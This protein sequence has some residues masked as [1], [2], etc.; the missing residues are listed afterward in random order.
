MA[1]N[2]F[3][4]LNVNRGLAG[5]GSVFAPKPRPHPPAE[6]KPGMFDKQPAKKPDNDETVNAG[7]IERW[8]TLPGGQKIPIKTKSG[9]GMLVRKPGSDN[10][11][12]P[13]D[14]TPYQID[15]L[16]PTGLKDAFDVAPAK[17]DGAGRLVKKV[18]DQVRDVGEDAEWVKKQQEA[19]TKKTAGEAKKAAAAE[20]KAA[21]TELTQRKTEELVRIGQA[22]TTLEERDKEARLVTRTARR[23]VAIVEDEIKGDKSRLDAIEN[24]LEAASGDLDKTAT[25]EAEKVK[26]AELLPAKEERR[27]KLKLNAQKA[28]LREEAWLRRSNREQSALEREAL[29]VKTMTNTGRRPSVESDT[30]VNAPTATTPP[31]PPPQPIN[32][33]TAYD[34]AYATEALRRDA[35]QWNAALTDHYGRVEFADSLGRSAAGPAISQ[36]VNRVLNTSIIPGM[37]QATA[38]DVMQ[39]HLPKVEGQR[40]NNGT[41]LV[42]NDTEVGKVIYQ[43]GVP[44]LRL[45]QGVA[46]IRHSPSLL[47]GNPYDGVPEYSAPTKQ[48]VDTFQRTRPSATL[49]Q[50][51]AGE[52]ADGGRTIEDEWKA[53]RWSAGQVNGLIEEWSAA[54]DGER[55]AIVARLQPEATLMDP[56]NPRLN[57]RRLFQEGKVSLQEARLLERE[58]YGIQPGFKPLAQAW[59]EYKASDAAKEMRDVL[60]DSFASRRQMVGALQQGSN[61]FLADYYKANGQRADFDLQEFNRTRATLMDEEAG[62]AHWTAAIDEAVQNA[63][64]SSVGIAFGLGK[65]FTLQTSQDEFGMIL[66]Q[67]GY[68]WAGLTNNLNDRGLKLMDPMGSAFKAG[69]NLLTGGKQ[70]WK[71]LWHGKEGSKVKASVETLFERID[72]ESLTETEFED[73][74]REILRSAVAVGRRAEF[75]EATPE[76]ER[77][78]LEDVREYYDPADPRSPLAG[79]L[80]A[81]QATRDPAI[82]AQFTSLL[83]S[84]PEEQDLQQKVSDYASSNGTVSADEFTGPL[85]LGFKG[86]QVAPVQE[87]LIEAVSNLASVGMGKLLTGGAKQAKRLQ[88]AGQAMNAMQKT[89][90]RIE[91]A[92]EWFAKAGTR[93][94]AT[95]RNFLIQGG[96]QAVTS[97]LGEGF[98][99]SV[100]AFTE[101]GASIGDAMAQGLTGIIGGIGLAPVHGLAGLALTTLDERRRD[102]LDSQQVKT[103]EDNWNKTHPEDP[104][105]EQDYRQMRAYLDPKADQSPA[106]AQAMT[107]LANN[108]VATRQLLAA[109]P[110]SADVLTPL[111]EERDQLMQQAQGIAAAQR[112][113]VVQAKQAMQEING[114]AEPSMRAFA[115]AAL[116]ARQGVPLTPKEQ[117]TLLNSTNDAGEV[118][119]EQGATGW[120]LTEAGLNSLGAAVPWTRQT[121]FPAEV[122]PA[123]VAT[124]TAPAA[125]PAGQTP[126]KQQ[127]PASGQP[128]TPATP[129]QTNPAGTT[130]APAAPL[131]T[132]KSE[133]AGAAVTPSSASSGPAAVAG[134]PTGGGVEAPSGEAG[135]LSNYPVAIMLNFPDGKVRRM[136]LEQQGTSPEDAAA[137]AMAS[138]AMQAYQRR[139][140]QVETL[141][142]N[143]SPSASATPEAGLGAGAA[144]TPTPEG[145]TENQAAPPSETLPE[146]EMGQRDPAEGIKQVIER[147]DAAQQRESRLYG[148]LLKMFLTVFGYKIVDTGIPSGYVD[149]WGT[150]HNLGTQ[151]FD[152]MNPGSDIGQWIDKVGN[153]SPDIVQHIQENMTQPY[154]HRVWFGHDPVANLG[155]IVEQFGVSALPEYALQ[156]LKDS[157]TK[158]GIP[159][160]GTQ[161]LVQSGLVGDR[162][163]TNWLS[164]NIGEALSGGLAIIGTYKLARKAKNGDPYSSGWAI[165]GVGFKLVGGAIQSNPVLILSG[166]TDLGILVA[167][168]PADVK[169]AVDLIAKQQAEPPETATTVEE[170]APE[171]P[172][173]ADTT[174]PPAPTEDLPAYGYL[175]GDAVAAALQGIP[176]TKRRGAIAV[177]DAL[178]DALGDY[179]DL[180]AA[181]EFQAGDARMYLR[182]DDALVIDLPDLVREYA[183]KPANSMV[184]LVRHELIHYAAGQVMSAQEMSNLWQ[185]LPYAIQNLVYKAYFAADILDEAR[186]SNAPSRWSSAEAY[187]M[188]HEFIRALVEESEFQGFVTEAVQADPNVGERIMRFLRTFVVRIREMLG[189]LPPGHRADVAEYE[190]RVRNALREMLGRPPLPS[191]NTLRSTGQRIE[192]L[193]DWSAQ[194]PADAR[195]WAA[196]TDRGNILAI[197]G[198]IASTSWDARKRLLTLARQQGEGLAYDAGMVSRNVEYTDATQQADL[199]A[200]QLARRGFLNDLHFAPA[201]SIDIM[202]QLAEGADERDYGWNNPNPTPAQLER[203]RQL[204]E[205]QAGERF[206]TDRESLTLESIP[207]LMPI[208]T[209][210]DLET[211]ETDNDTDALAAMTERLA[212]PEQLE[213]RLDPI[214]RRRSLSGK[215]D[216]TAARLQEQEAKLKA[217]EAQIEAFE[218]T[219]LAPLMHEEVVAIKQIRRLEKLLGQLER[220]LLAGIPV[221]ARQLPAAAMV[222]EVEQEA[223]QPPAPDAPPPATP[224]S[225]EAKQKAREAFAGLIDDTPRPPPA[226]EETPP[227]P[228][229]LA[230]TPD[231]EKKRRR[232]AEP[233]PPPPAAEGVGS[234]EAK[235]KARAAFAGLI[236]DTTTAPPA[237]PASPTPPEA[238]I[239]DFGQKIG[240]ARKDTWKAT[241]LNVD[242]LEG[243]TP[244]ERASFV[245]KD[246]VWPKP[247]YAVWVDAGMP[248]AVAM[249]IKRFRDALPTMPSSITG[250]SFRVPQGDMQ[251]QY[252]EVLSI[253]RDKMPFAKTRED[254]MAIWNEVTQYKGTGRTFN[255]H[256]MALQ[257]ATG[258]SKSHYRWTKLFEKAV[259]DFFNSWR[260]DNLE[261]EVAESG[262]PAAGEPWMKA[263]RI[264]TVPVGTRMWTREKGQIVTT[265]PHF[266]V[267]SARKGRS[268]VILSS[269]HKTQESAIAWAKTRYELDQEGRKKAGGTLSRPLKPDPKRESSVDYRRNMNMTGEDLVEAFK[270]RGGEFGNWTNQ[271]DRQQALNFAYD[272]MQ[273]L[274]RILGI[275]PKAVSLNG[276][277]GIA[278]GARGKGKAAAHYELSKVVINLTRTSGAGALA[279]EW[280]H[281]LDHYFGSVIAQVGPLAMLSDE[282]SIKLRNIRPEMAEA[283]V[284]V[285]RAIMLKAKDLESVITE[286]RA[287]V[288]R[289]KKSFMSWIPG[290]RDTWSRDLKDL[291]DAA[292]G[293]A[294]RM[295]NGAPA[296]IRDFIPLIL[297]QVTADTGKAFRKS[298][299]FEQN[300]RFLEYKENILAKAEA[301]EL[302]RTGE[303]PTRYAENAKKLGAYWERR[304]ELFARAF[305]SYIQDRLEGIGEK[306]EYLVHSA[307]GGATGD[308][309]WGTAY[310]EGDE[311]AAIFKA[312]D[313]LFGTVQQEVTETGVRL[314]APRPAAA[315]TAQLGLP[316]ARLPA[317]LDLAQTLI[318]EQINTPAALAAFLDGLFPGGAA[319]P[320]SQAL[321]DALGMVDPTLRGT[322]DWETVYA[323]EQ[324]APEATPEASN[325]T[326]SSEPTPEQP[327]PPPAAEE[328]PEDAPETAIDD[329]TAYRKAVEGVEN[330]IRFAM[331]KARVQFTQPMLLDTVAKAMGTP[332]SAGVWSIKDATDI[333]EV[334]INRILARPGELDI[335]PGQGNVVM[336]QAMVMRLKERLMA[337]IPTQTRR[338]AEMDRM[339]QF[340]TPPTLSFA[341]AWVGK[342]ED[343]DVLLEPSAGLAGLAMWGKL[344]GAH[345]IANELSPRRVELL[346]L[347]GIPNV[348]TSENAEHLFAIMEPQMKDGTIRRPTLVIMNPPFSNAANVSGTDTMVGARHLEQA[349]KLLAPG[350]RLVAIVGRGMAADK[351][352]FKAWWAKIGK[353]YDVRA[354]IGV[355]G[356]EYA[357]YGTTFDNQ[358]VVIDKLPPNPDR[359]V[360]TGE[361]RTVEELLPLL[362]PVRN[363]RPA[364][365]PGK[366]ESASPEPARPQTDPRP[367]TGGVADPSPSPDTG[368]NRPSGSGARPPRG[369]G[370]SG[371]S[372]T[373]QLD[374]N[375]PASESS[376]APAND[377]TGDTGTPAT[378]P[379]PTR[380]TQ[381][382]SAAS[383]QSGAVRDTAT[384][385]DATPRELSE[386]EVFAE[387]R[388]Q[389]ARFQGSAAHPSP[390]VESAAMGAV[391]APDINYTPNLPENVIQKGLLSDA[392]LEAVTYA[393]QAH[394][395]APLDTG[396]TR[397][398]FIGDGTGVGKGRELSGIIVDNWRQGRRRAVWLSKSKGLARDA[399]RDLDGL[400]FQEIPIV[401][402][403]SAKA[404]A[405]LGFKEGVLFT[406]YSTLRGGHEG[407]DPEGNPRAGTKPSRFKQLVDALGRDFDGVIALDESHMAGNAVD[408]KG[409][410]GVKKASKQGLAIVD[411]Q[412]VFP[413]ARVVYASATGATEPQNFSYAERLGLWGQGTPFPNKVKF[414]DAI[415]AQ[416]VSAMEILARDLKALGSYISRTLSFKGVDYSRTV[417]NVTEDQTKLYDAMARS[418]QMVF[419][420]VDA[421]LGLTNGNRNG[422]ARSAA[423]S[424]F[425]SSNQRFFNQVLTSLQMPTILADMQKRLDEGNSV[426]LQ[427]VN[428]NEAIQERALAEV[429]KDKDEADPLAL[430]MLDMSPKDVL[431]QYVKNGWPTHLYEEIEDDNGNSKYVLVTDAQGKPVESPE[432]I[433]MREETLN[434]LASLQVPDNPL[435]QILDT[436]GADAV[437]EIT[438]RS[439]RVVRKLQP[440]GTM[441]RIVEANRSDARRNVEA[442]EFQ[443]GKRRILIFSDAGGTG[444]SYHAAVGAKN[445]Q[446]RFHYLVQ[447]GWR[448]DNAIQGFG[449]THRSDQ[450]TPPF[451]V[452][453]STNIRGH[454]RFISTIARRLAQLGAL[455]TGER[456]AAGQGMFT[457]TDNLEGE[458]AQRAVRRLFSDLYENKVPGLDFYGLTGRMGYTRTI[459][460][461]RGDEVVVSTLIDPKTGALSVDKTPTVQQFLNRI[462]ALEIAEQNQVFD[463]FLAGM[464]RLIEQA[465]ADGSY[466]PGVQTFKADRVELA[467][468]ETVYTHPGTSSPTRLVTVKAS[469]RI[470]YKEFDRINRNNPTWVRNKRSGRVYAI[471]SNTLTRTTAAGSIVA[472]VWKTSPADIKREDITDFQG[473]RLREYYDVLTPED[474]RPLWEEEIRTGGEF[475]VKDETF[476]V[477]LMLPVWDRAKMP[478]MRV[479]RV[480]PSTPDVEPFLGLHIPRDQVNEVRKRLGAGIAKKTPAAYFED[481]LE[482]GHTLDLANGW[483]VSRVKSFGEPRIEL[484]GPQY[485]HLKEIE[486]WGGFGERISWSFRYFLPGTDKEGIAAFEKLITRHPVVSAGPGLSLGAP[487]PVSIDTAADPSLELYRKRS[488][489]GQIESE[490]WD[491][492]PQWNRKINQNPDTAE[493]EWVNPETPS[494]DIQRLISEY[495]SLA[496]EVGPLPRKG[497]FDPT[498]LLQASIDIAA[499]SAATSPTN[500]LP[501]PTAAQKEAGNYPKGHARISGLDITIENPAG[502][503]RS[504]V[505]KGGKAWS[506]AMKDHYGY[507]KGT[508]GPDGDHL[509]VFIAP[510]TPTDYRGP[511]HVVE[512]G[513]KAGKGFDEHKAII[514]VQTAAEA[515]ELYQRNYAPDW[516]GGKAIQTMPWEVFKTWATSK[517]AA[518][519]LDGRRRLFAPRPVSVSPAGFY[520]TLQEAIRAKLPARATKEQA[521][522][523]VTGN[524]KAE[525]V[526]WSGVLPWIDQQEG[527]VDKEALLAFL[528][529]EGAVEL[530]EVTMGEYFSEVEAW[531]NDEGGAN[532]ETPFW[533]LTP[534][535]QRNAIQQYRDEVAP[536]NEESPKYAQYQLPGA[537]NYREVVLSMTPNTAGAAGMTLDAMARALGFSGWHST[538]TPAQKDQVEKAWAAQP[539]G[540]SN[541][542]GRPVVQPTKQNYTSSHFPNVPNYVAHMRLNERT[543]ATGATGLFVEEL[544]SDRHQA[545]REK[546]Y[547]NQT[548]RSE[549]E[550]ARN[551]YRDAVAH[552]GT[553]PAETASVLYERAHD[554]NPEI[555]WNW[556]KNTE[557]QKWQNKWS[558]QWTSPE[559]Q[560]QTI[561]AIRTQRALIEDLRLKAEQ[562]ETRTRQAIPDAPFRKDWPLALFKRALR[563]AVATGKDWIGWTTGETQAERFDLSKQVEAIHAERRKTF[564]ALAITDKA[565][566]TTEQRVP[567]EKLPDFVGKD[568]ARKIAEEADDNPDGKEYSGLDLK[569]GGE[570]MKGFYDTIL[571]KEIAKYVKQWGATVEKGNAFTGASTKATPEAKAAIERNDRLGFDRTSEALSAVLSDPN[572]AETWDVSPADAAILQDWKNASAQQPIWRISITPAMREGVQRGQPLFAPAPVGTRPKKQKKAPPAPVVSTSSIAE[573]ADRQQAQSAAASR[574][575]PLTR[576]L[577]QPA[578]F[579]QDFN[580]FY[581]NK[582][583]GNIDRIDYYAPG[584]R[585]I[586][587]DTERNLALSR[588][589]VNGLF[590]NLNA[591][592]RAGFGY[593]AWWKNP[594]V[595]AEW[596]RFQA[597]LLPVAARLEADSVDDQGQFVWAPFNM[598]AGQISAKLVKDQK[599][600]EGDTINAGGEMLVIGPAFSRRESTAGTGAGRLVEYHLLLRPMAEQEQAAIYQEFVDRWQH[601]PVVKDLLDEFIMPGMD[602]ARYVGPRQFRTAEFNRY[603]LRDFFNEWPDEIR[604]QFGALPEMDYV[605]GYVPEVP[606]KSSTPGI[607]GVI[608]ELIRSYTSPTRRVETRGLR[609]RGDVKD[610]FSGFQTTL[611][612]AHLEKVRMERRGRLLKAAAVPMDKI[613]RDQLDRWVPIN[614]AFESVYDAIKLARN[615]DPDR[616]PALTGALNPAQLELM[617][618]LV[619]EAFALRGQNLAIPAPVF[620][621]MLAEV[622]TMATENLFLSLLQW[623]VQQFN[624]AALAS[625]QYLGMNFAGNEIMKLAFATQQAYRGLLLSLH[626]KNASASKRRRLAFATFRGLLTGMF[627]DRF[628]L[629]QER[630][631][632]ILPRELFDTNHFYNALDGLDL[633]VLDNLKRL[634]FG[635]A[636]L[637]AARTSNWDVG[638]KVQLANAMYQ[639]HAR[640]AWREQ[641]KANPAM[642]QFTAAQKRAWLKNYVATAPASVHSEI[643]WAAGEWLMNYENTPKWM[644]SQ[645]IKP[646]VDPSRPQNAGKAVIT[647][648]LQKLAIALLIPFIRWSYLFARRLKRSSWNEG[649]KQLTTRKGDK[650][651]GLANL[652]ALGT[653]LAAPASLA[654][655]G[656]GD[657]DD[658][659]KL[660]AELLGRN[661]DVEGDDLDATLRTTNRFNASGLARIVWSQMG[662]SE[663]VDF[664][665]RDDA[666][667]E[668]DLWMRYRN[669]PYIKEGIVMGLWLATLEQ[670][671]A[672][673]APDRIKRDRTERNPNAGVKDAFGQSIGA[674][675]GEYVSL[676]IGYSLIENIYAAGS[677]GQGSAQAAADLRGTAIDFVTA[678]VLPHRLLRDVNVMLDPVDRRD[679]PSKSLGYVPGWKEAIMSRIPGLKPK[680]PMEGK[681]ATPAIFSSKSAVPTPEQKDLLKHFDIPATAVQYTKNKGSRDIFADLR[682]LR[683]LGGGPQD[684][685]LSMSPTNKPM[686]AYPSPSQVRQRDVATE[687]VRANTPFNLLPV[688]RAAYAKAIRGQKDE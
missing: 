523:I 83:L 361:V 372:G 675:L 109:G 209:V 10:L 37:N 34:L 93:E 407:L 137:R 613:P 687:M 386:D 432:A 532:E 51:T 558:K 412:K 595:W 170:A 610:L 250:R 483:R 540:P 562:A 634:Q 449:R 352:R 491:L 306:N 420:N 342:V 450:V 159:L 35:D 380:G 679:L 147:K 75:S 538:L 436:F 620:Q 600:Q 398:F 453:V 677:N 484:T 307:K 130:P 246:Q 584:F 90:F 212:V 478:L 395:A 596:R 191:P 22:K 113:Q 317:F 378:D 635:S 107:A 176:E 294:P 649:I 542:D 577:R 238:K 471:E 561:Q 640:E 186:P 158:S 80:L 579:S 184:T 204:E 612:Q 216:A 551:A 129:A 636:F 479:F 626:W 100:A 333:M 344:R 2:P 652:L 567:L 374:T 172:P 166:L 331:F 180:F 416:G 7:N 122:A 199:A 285:M 651:E 340:S 126:N 339:Q 239:E 521:A 198:N 554:N 292:V 539:Y 480:N 152:K 575:T 67:S 425:W 114:I 507:V 383:P 262:W 592:A 231:K 403:G 345:V 622:A 188:G 350:G 45:N 32:D 218:G 213:L 61:T 23:Q 381:P 245:T 518:Q 408:Q 60:G 283:Y 552:W 531:W 84:T 439:R 580:D 576:A 457:D 574:S 297:R 182:D 593:P 534:A 572:F 460:D 254:L 555:K 467:A 82:K 650:R 302:D 402:Q 653:L 330:L 430:E 322:H 274:A 235:A 599:K 632:Q 41:T 163:A 329:T 52:V 221:V 173:A 279:H 494:M 442:K 53:Q 224:G 458:Y 445:R 157:T 273:D 31:P 192:K 309:P 257:T 171:A 104:I 347:T 488:Y 658:P 364:L 121:Y 253:F 128:A 106:L 63:A 608:G 1:S 207:V 28:A 414:F 214:E 440:D 549:A 315:A 482:H 110:P 258:K 338:T 401:E 406:T 112:L 605:A 144:T 462:L 156:L 543:D 161:Y 3:A 233:T 219:D 392:Q 384:V 8:I 673:P 451:Y 74:S 132:P 201:E 684:I 368:A 203:R 98:E 664:T 623:F 607:V 519:P 474:A 351:A 502:S 587:L 388:P 421:S 582:I 397:G 446:R 396:E 686:I 16:S 334:A 230:G 682:A 473:P 29:A 175:P 409:N 522:A 475:K 139:G 50:M 265:E 498:Q 241:G 643:E 178:N 394:N 162:A 468:D 472:Q 373:Q 335:D 27:D 96:K 111:F 583:S 633:G 280:A 319:R 404:A 108:G 13:S 606:I 503:T 11:F 602:K 39:R 227:T 92:G 259:S 278:F 236:D 208:P 97:G 654:F 377:R 434:R 145:A 428:T 385:E 526:K 662:L 103:F 54:N 140:A 301:G 611:M 105:T 355:D 590:Q 656:E 143:P 341:A 328:T 481:V 546:G 410:R 348:V 485:D 77:L 362:A 70:A 295:I 179:G 33:E 569:V 174:P 244:E 387:Y 604:D 252:V 550:A 14:G 43:N 68:A 452:L 426:V 393:G 196:I 683:K 332:V 131:E 433:A 183:D 195:Y 225:E 629:R 429:G 120:T 506:I 94:G 268:H 165:A 24:A 142:V 530:Q 601:F 19:A 42:S 40:L 116:R 627:R 25:L 642:R 571:P 417:H 64:G 524:G 59:E 560:Q 390:L 57:T 21:A 349:L 353:E 625:F 533:E 87:V 79:L 545:G 365:T 119:A 594:K 354:N 325:E 260:F 405:K 437:A 237:P 517:H 324:P 65:F 621:E 615:L 681:V 286:N 461:E 603:A 529:N 525:E 47:S 15:P 168:R 568:L 210:K 628:P 190:R 667:Q 62:W 69:W 500:A 489:L 56:Q 78:A 242:N 444:F 123:P 644:N 12:D 154:F 337:I 668:Q 124:G 141:P 559:H 232:K 36:T 73:L 205:S 389:K 160:P 287:A 18:G 367:E 443:D 289:G 510:G 512:Q 589:A 276:R 657:D 266:D 146:N 336:A 88:E 455:T 150:A 631:R 496:L 588:A 413:K 320:Y 299:P 255:E 515:A 240:G 5:S 155:T 291:V 366:T 326:P 614:D 134:Q 193:R 586:W 535:E 311:A 553:M 476:I 271:A 357:R 447:A 277:L 379:S 564:W 229:P 20:E 630:L 304:H 228:P 194:Q 464:E 261:K 127:S 282:N 125:T 672:Q 469:D 17:P 477:G 639:A 359:K 81:Y 363:E 527:K 459:M 547:A 499:N 167:T 66:D 251:T 314:Y 249:L 49:G 371:I 448:A 321:W 520:S 200:A 343:T 513:D 616:F 185:S 89:A 501:Q 117:Q 536:F 102:K 323:G 671:D 267:V 95:Y 563:D 666:G 202:R 422:N 85:K 153:A 91:Q 358:I 38:K 591:R 419:Q 197:P 400:G 284:K 55:A 288:E 220:Q 308:D 263:Y 293:D 169:A 58:F 76:G 6:P 465:Q 511:V 638:A 541:A 369:G 438:G 617:R 177:L 655:L 688:N 685:G 456:K 660:P 30:G 391:E 581:A 435:E 151:L 647:A 490:L 566:D 411:L 118:L 133:Q 222:P 548:D 598:R 243:M 270:F 557:V 256:V 497:Y 514:G 136:E 463:V 290:N 618:S 680:L 138:P 492:D 305:E 415:L 86:A 516:Q 187:M 637:A 537:E 181:L 493:L 26:I 327:A 441:K 487:R 646:Y 316:P 223:E 399:R 310:P 370:Q 609:E 346:K 206:R 296:R 248:P 149:S 300:A 312:F 356:R 570:G 641:V 505:D 495:N 46:G 597:E 303:V 217:V 678:P 211:A 670:S 423:M 676:G 264:V 189:R 424:A 661:R 44:E 115:D 148:N 234:E 585:N 659:D 556:L 318:A 281:A 164:M 427:I 272:A 48:F 313:N 269:E 573:E 375:A 215:R 466:D 470:Y 418:W 669:Y 4:P 565:G 504:G 528:E 99:E 431:L 247:N 135:P 275:D 624:A 665:L 486:S 72:T 298:S 226:A 101:T 663:D 544:Q 508:E 360:V 454:M 376:P 578:Q 619:G 509:D 9:S 71:D 648:Q 382:N 645:S 674:L